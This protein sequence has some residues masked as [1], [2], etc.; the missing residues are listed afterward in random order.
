MRALRFDAF[1][2][3]SV[4]HLADVAD[5]VAGIGFAVVR[6]T[7]ASI[8]PSDVKNVAGAM[9][10]TSLP[11]TP[12]RDFAGVVEG[13]PAEWLGREVFGT[14]GDLGFTV[15]GTHAESLVVPVSALTPKPA[16]LTAAEAASVGVTSVVAWQGLIEYAVLQP[17]EVVAVIGVGGGVG[18]AVAQLARWRG[19]SLIVGVDVQAPA[20][21]SPAEHAIDRFVPSDAN[22]TDAVRQATGGSGANVVF[23]AVGG[24]TFERALK[25]LA[26]QGRLVTISATGRARVEFDLRDFYHNESRIIGADSRKFDASASAQRLAA[27]L[28]AF[29]SGAIAAPPIDEVVPLNRAVEAYERV[30]GG[31]RARFVL[32]P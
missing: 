5:P 9:E 11:R 18:T 26:Q 13:G 10:G 30:A 6:V 2:D 1:G 15:D 14:G 28:P 27:M 21:D 4:L 17:G 24:V 23:D 29:E 22:L 19:A 25:S 31:A 20:P 16:H 7:G 12:G 8:N 32:A 3:P